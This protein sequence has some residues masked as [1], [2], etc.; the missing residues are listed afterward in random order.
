M[1][2]E[3]E[4]GGRTYESQPAKSTQGTT[5]NIG[6]TAEYMRKNSEALLMLYD[7]VRSGQEAFRPVSIDR[8]IEQVMQ[9]VHDETIEKQQE[10]LDNIDNDA[11]R[12]IASEQVREFIKGDLEAV[13]NTLVNVCYFTHLW[14]LINT[15]KAKG[16]E[17]YAQPKVRGIIEQ[18]TEVLAEALN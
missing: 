7:C 5:N 18:V 11:L 3:K 13:V 17:E 4:R 10:L 9:S 1:Q 15:E 8:H 14:D 2:K 16:F 6:S 12:E